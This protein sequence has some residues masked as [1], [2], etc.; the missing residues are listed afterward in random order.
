MSM[1][2]IGFSGLEAI[3]YAIKLGVALQLTNILLQQLHAPLVRG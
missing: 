3:P 2:I 1:H